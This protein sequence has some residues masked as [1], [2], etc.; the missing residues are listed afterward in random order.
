MKFLRSLRLSFRLKLSLGVLS[1]IVLS[2]IG[3]AFTAVRTVDS[4]FEDH[5][6][7]DQNVSMKLAAHLVRAA[8]PGTEV[9]HSPSGVDRIRAPGL[10]DA[11]ENRLVDSISQIT[12][13]SAVIFRWDAA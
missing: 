1:I 6:Q 13:G 9:L 8:L 10:P 12:G 7:S 3:V 4:R 11:G 2:A 5:F